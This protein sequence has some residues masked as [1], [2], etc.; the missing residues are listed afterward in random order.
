MIVLSLSYFH[1]HRYMADREYIMAAIYMRIYANYRKHARKSFY[2]G[3][4][5][6]MVS[7]GIYLI[8]LNYWSTAE[9]SMISIS[10]FL[11][12]GCGLAV[13]GYTLWTMTNPHRI[14]DKSNAGHMRFLAVFQ[15]K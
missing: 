12:L 8:P 14:C 7:I 6:F 9:H 13:I 10:V 11:V 3:L 1:V 15:Q 2:F 5:T 4:V